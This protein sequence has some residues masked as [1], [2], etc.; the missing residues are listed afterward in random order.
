MTAGL[1]PRVA[2]V[3]LADGSPAMLEEA[4]RNLSAHHNVTYGLMQDG[5]I[6]LPD[7]AVDAA[8][9]NM[10]LHHCTDP[11]AAIAEMARDHA[12]RRAAG[13]HRHG[14]ARTHLDA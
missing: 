11:A 1:A 14:G 4:G 10:Y 9:A 2:Q 5:R 6:P 8:F 13:D 3:H 12:A 7:G